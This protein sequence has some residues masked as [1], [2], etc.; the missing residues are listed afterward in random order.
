MTSGLPD[1][2]KMEYSHLEKIHIPGLIKQARQIHIYPK[3]KTAPII[4]LGVLC[5]DG[6]TIT[7]D[8]QVM[9][10]HKNGQEII[11]GTRNKQTGMW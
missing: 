3:T 2:S 7:I 8:N 6:C 9:S 10:V 4:S 11:K 1:C 5:D